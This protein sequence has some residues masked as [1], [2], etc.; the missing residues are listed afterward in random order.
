MKN[1]KTP[2][3]PPCPKG[4]IINNLIFCVVHKRID[5]TLYTFLYLSTIE[6]NEK[7]KQVK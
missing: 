4:E 7:Q 6:K 3:P 1:K 5:H 2:N